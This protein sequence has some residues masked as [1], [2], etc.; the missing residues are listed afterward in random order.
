MFSFAREARILYVNM[1]WTVLD[2]SSSAL[3]LKTSRCEGKTAQWLFISKVKTQ[4][5]FGL[6][7][8][9]GSFSWKRKEKQL[10]LQIKWYKTE[11]FH[12]AKKN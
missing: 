7:W 4:A 1:S 2:L 8:N 3:M 11:G 9:E 12:G 10:L 6:A 5:T